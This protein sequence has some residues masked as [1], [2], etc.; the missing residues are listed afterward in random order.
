MADDLEQN[1]ISIKPG[2]I[3]PTSVRQLEIP[4]ETALGFDLAAGYATHMLVQR[5]EHEFFISFFEVSPPILTGNAEQ[6]QKKLDELK[7]VPTRCI[8]RVIVSAARMPEFVKVL[9]N[10]LSATHLAPSEY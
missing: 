3:D 2:A 4:Y 8:A 7:Y 6:I 1:N 9:E 10:S 5:T